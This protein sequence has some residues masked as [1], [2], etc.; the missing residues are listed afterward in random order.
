[1]TTRE[2][3]EAATKA[4]AEARAKLSELVDAERTERLAEQDKIRARLALKYEEPIR[5]A[6]M[7]ANKAESVRDA[8]NVEHSIALMQEHIGKPVVEWRRQGSIYRPSQNLARTG[9][10]GTIEVFKDG[11]GYVGSRYFAPKPGVLVVRPRKKD[12]KPAVRCEACTIAVDGSVVLP[13][14]WYYEGDDPNSVEGTQA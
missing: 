6:R 4:W 3:A 7:A 1:M 2:K 10:T 14:G 9:T 8:A 12:G 11:D 13:R 5:V